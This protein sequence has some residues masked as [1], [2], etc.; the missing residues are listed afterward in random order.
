MSVQLVITTLNRP[1]E[2]TK[3]VEAAFRSDIELAG[4]TIID[5]SS[6]H[7]ASDLYGDLKAVDVITLPHA[8][9]L[10]PC[11]NLAFALY[12][13][14]LICQNDDVAVQA[15]TLRA[16]VEAAESQP[17]SALFYANHDDESMFSLFLLR[18]QAF[19]EVGGF[20]P[21][22][23]PLFYEDIDILYRLA[24]LGYAPTTVR[25][26]TYEHVKN[27]TIKAFD[28]Q[29]KELHDRQFARNEAYYRTKWGGLKFEEKFK[30]PFNGERP[31]VPSLVAM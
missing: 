19:L 1:A 18:K 11:L 25:E 10:G 29:R 17:G 13:D 15:H 2:L 22:I 27:G 3:A 20:D 4:I 28:L 24:L 23:V 16:L 26:A 21:A 9:G 30:V 8:A 31:V 14:H 12:N 7:Y 6:E 5:N